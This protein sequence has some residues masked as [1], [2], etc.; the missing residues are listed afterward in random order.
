MHNILYNNCIFL[1]IFKQ[2]FYNNISHHI[3]QVITI[4]N[5]ENQQIYIYILSNI[6]TDILIIYTLNIIISI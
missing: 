2:F 1:K 3:E 5:Y 6:Y 4:S